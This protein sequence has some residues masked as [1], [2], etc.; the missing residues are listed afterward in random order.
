MT[1]DTKYYQVIATQY[2]PLEL[3]EFDLYVIWHSYFVYPK[4]ARD[5]PE[6][7]SGLPRMRGPIH[8]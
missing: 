6:T 1:D 2:S 4:G 3:N 8:P 7:A 5:V